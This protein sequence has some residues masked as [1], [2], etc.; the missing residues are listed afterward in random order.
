MPIGS[1]QEWLPAGD[2]LLWLI[3]A[4]AGALAVRVPDFVVPLGSA[5]TRLL[6]QC[7][8]FFSLG[9]V[10]GVVRPSRSWRWAFAAILLVPVA[11]W[12]WQLQPGT[13][14]HYRDVEQ[15]LGLIQERAGQY[16]ALGV[17]ALCGALLGG[18]VASPR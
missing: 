4:V 15:V 10:L 14:L 12:L 17:A 13:P 5:W 11:E 18:A 8:A 2:G 16:T 3:G 6:V 9:C 7:G 1:R